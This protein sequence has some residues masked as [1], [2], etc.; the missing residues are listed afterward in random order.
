MLLCVARAQSCDEC[1]LVLARQLERAEQRAGAQAHTRPGQFCTGALLELACYGAVTVSSG[2]CVDCPCAQNLRAMTGAPEQSGA[3]ALMHRVDKLVLKTIR[4][5]RNDFG[6]VEILDELV[7]ALR[8]VGG[9]E[10]CRC[11][12]L[13]HACGAR[14]FFTVSW[15]VHDSLRRGATSIGRCVS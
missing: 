13:C 3:A 12:H 11:S 5:P 2:A 15:G 8:G 4:T 9:P 7:V 10:V 1:R 14:H 6:I